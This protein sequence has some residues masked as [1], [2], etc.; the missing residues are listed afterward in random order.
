LPPIESIEAVSDLKAFLAPGVPLELTR[1]A[2]R[3]AWTVTPTIRDFIGL[4]ENAWDFNTPGGVPGFGSI[5]L[6]DVR[7]LMAELSDESQAA[8]PGV[9]GAAKVDHSATLAES[10][11]LV[12]VA[13]ALPNIAA[14]QHE[15]DQRKARAFRRRHGGA[16][17]Q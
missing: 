10:T 15:D 5:D 3:R 2:L 7:Q 8:A 1:A 17:P 13:E 16:L 14:T 9:A 11:P 4:S 12:S 6:E